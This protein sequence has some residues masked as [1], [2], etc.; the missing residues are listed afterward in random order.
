MKLDEFI[1]NVL[2]DIEKGLKE[3]EKTTGKEYFIDPSGKTKGVNFDIAVTVI[4]SKTESKEGSVK[5]GFVQVIG[6][7]VGGKI[8][9]KEES[10]KVSRIQFTVYVPK[11][12]KLELEQIS[13][14]YNQRNFSID[15]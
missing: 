5:T 9:N 14:N 8:E 4:D 7:G 12:T 11:T 10:S 2:L 1:R 6:A 3:A 15:Y 13:S